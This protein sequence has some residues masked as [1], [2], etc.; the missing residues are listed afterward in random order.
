MSTAVMSSVLGDKWRMHV[1]NVT[2]FTLFAL[3][4]NGLVQA[5]FVLQEP[6]V[7]G[8]SMG[9]SIIWAYFELFGQD[10]LIAKAIFVD[11]TPLQVQA[12]LNAAKEIDRMSRVVS[13]MA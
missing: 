4:A 13:V 5:P 7:V 9:A 12:T 1:P 10:A 3:C 8:S 11:Q 2:L 6:T